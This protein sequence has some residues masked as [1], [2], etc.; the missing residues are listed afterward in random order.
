MSYEKFAFLYDKLMDEAPY[1]SWFQYTKKMIEEYNPNAKKVLDVGCGTGEMLIRYLKAGF[2]AQG[3][4]LS[5]NMLAVA[6]QKLNDE[7]L[8]CL[9]YE[10]DMRSLEGLG[11]F[12]VITVYC[13]SLN[14]LETEEDVI[15]AFHEF[16]QLLPQNGL[17]LFDVHS[18]YKIHHIF[19]GATFAEDTGDIAYIWNVFEGE[20]ENSVE[21]ELTFFIRETK[22]Y[23][24]K[25]EE[26]HFQ[27]TYSIKEYMQ[28]LS[29]ADFTLLKI[30]GDFNDE[31]SETTERIF[32]ALRR[33]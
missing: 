2:D 20:H 17:L 24:E 15:Q 12:D 10:R 3:L 1:D 30:S 19:N 9:L 25:F 23:Y 21:H 13:D 4:D 14:Y 26:T 5:A 7:G 18:L 28:W 31:I 11:T 6:Q 27:R 32:F 33:N 8:N 16:Y 29:E 22:D